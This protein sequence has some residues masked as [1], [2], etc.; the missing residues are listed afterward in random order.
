[1][2]QLPCD[3][4]GICMLYKS[5][6]AKEDTITC[7]TCVTPWHINCLTTTLLI[8]KWE[9]PDCSPNP[10]NIHKSAIST[11]SSSGELIAT[12]RVIQNDKLLT[13][14]EKAK[15]RQDLMSGGVASSSSGKSSN[16]DVFDGSFNCFFCMQLLDRPVTTPC[17]HNLC[18]KCFQKWTGQ[19]KR[20]CVKCRGVIP[21]KMASQPRINSAIVVV[22][23]M[24]KMS[25]ISGLI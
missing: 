9:C 19:G 6:T 8:D 11:S 10:I 1:M 5:K 12:I 24:A 20:T 21:S 15:R 17:G 14:Q 22:I 18:L 13:E 16:G 2:A 4:D 7:K 25:P 3:G 23:R